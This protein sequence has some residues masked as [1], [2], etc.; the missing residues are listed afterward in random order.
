MQK[1][2]FSSYVTYL[3]HQQQCHTC[4][5]NMLWQRGMQSGYEIAKATCCDHYYQIRE[6]KHTSTQ[7]NQSNEFKDDLGIAV[8]VCIGF[9]IG[10]KL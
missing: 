5:S 10:I 6:Q 4:G 3:T 8:A 9:L 7:K 1:N 2:T